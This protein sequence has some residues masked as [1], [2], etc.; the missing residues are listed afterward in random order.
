MLNFD[1]FSLTLG[2]PLVLYTKIEVIIAINH[3]D[4][5]DIYHI[6]TF[7]MSSGLVPDE[8]C[9]VMWIFICINAYPTI[10]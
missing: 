10:G 4:S 9:L 1:S 3:K 2:R 5:C 7:P 8:L 6:F